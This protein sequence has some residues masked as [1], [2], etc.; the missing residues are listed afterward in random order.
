MLDHSQEQAFIWRGVVII[1]AL[2]LLYLFEVTLHSCS[3]GGHAHSHNNVMVRILP[4][5]IINLIVPSCEKFAFSFLIGNTFLYRTKLCPLLVLWYIL[6]KKFVSVS[7]Y[8]IVN[9][10]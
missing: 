8:V 4:N 3:A 5:N 2:Y 6:L 7:K 9:A 10:R 1:G